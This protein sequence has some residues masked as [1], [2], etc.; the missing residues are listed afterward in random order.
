VFGAAVFVVCAMHVALYA[1]AGRENA[2]GEAFISI[3]IG[4]TGTGIGLAE[5][6][7]AVLGLSLLPRFWLAYFDF[8]SIRGERILGELQGADQVAFARDAYV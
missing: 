5:I 8:F 2:L 4:V 6:A 3:G 7:A 1:L